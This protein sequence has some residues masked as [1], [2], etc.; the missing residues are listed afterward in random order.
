MRTHGGSGSTYSYGC[1]C[2]ECRAAHSKR[3]L[4][5]RRRRRKQLPYTLLYHGEYSTYIN[6]QCRCEECRDAGRR[7]AAAK[8]KRDKKKA[9]KEG[10]K[11]SA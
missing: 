3:T 6:W 2:D 1:R 9:R 7:Y 11:A 8:R 5:A 10:R 4:L